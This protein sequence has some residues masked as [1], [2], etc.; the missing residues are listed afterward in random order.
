[1]KINIFLGSFII[2]LVS[3]KYGRR[4]ALIVAILLAGGSGAIATFVN[5]RTLFA[6]LRITVGMGGMGCFMVPAVIAG[7]VS[8]TNVVKIKRFKFLG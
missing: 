1:M 6:I 2:G 4:K 7:M 8:S 5:N 3:D